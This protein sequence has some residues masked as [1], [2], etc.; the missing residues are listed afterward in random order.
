MSAASLK[1]HPACVR[2]LATRL[3][4]FIPAP[5]AVTG[6][7]DRSMGSST[8]PPA[9]ACIQYGNSKASATRCP[10]ALRRPSVARPV[11][12]RSYPLAEARTWYEIR[13]ALIHA[14]PRRVSSGAWRRRVTASSVQ[15]RERPS[16]WPSAGC[17]S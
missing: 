17:Q 6:R 7:Q 12:I 8:S 3:F 13:I 2:K 1:K 4:V 9:R 15:S 14:V 5:R 10:L 11:D 16:S